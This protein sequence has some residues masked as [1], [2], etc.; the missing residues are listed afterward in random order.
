MSLFLR[1]SHGKFTVPSSSRL[2][3]LWTLKDSEVTP[4]TKNR[5]FSVLWN[6]SLLFNIPEGW[7]KERTSD[8]DNQ[9]DLTCRS[10]S[11]IP[12]TNYSHGNHTF[13]GSTRGLKGIMTKYAD[14]YGVLSKQNK[15]NHLIQE[16]CVNLIGF[17]YIQ[18][19][20]HFKGGWL[21]EEHRVGW[22]MS[23]VRTNLLRDLGLI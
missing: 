13:E 17:I 5:W 8:L 11:I 22:T 2:D 1:H 4:N 23:V 18:P 10:L 7:Q 15:M 12:E 3:S 9:V 6:Q 20:L 16:E 14:L 19:S 21:L